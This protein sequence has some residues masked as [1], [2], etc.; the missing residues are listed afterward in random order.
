MNDRFKTLVRHFFSR[1][2][3]KDS[4]SPGAEAHASVVQIVAMLAL[5]G[6]FLSLAMIS[7]HALVRSEFTRRWLRAGD[8]YVFVSYA[9]VVMGFVMT[10][11]WDSLFPDRRDYIILTP[12][13]I[14]LRAFFAAKV[15][16]LC[17]FLLLF[18]IAINFFSCIIVPYAYLLRINRLDV[19]LPA[20]LAH[21]A[22]ALGGSVF[23][24]MFFAALQGVL[25]NLMTPEAFRRVSPWI[26]M[27]SMTILV[28]VL[29]ITPGISAN[30]QPLIESNSR[31][32]DYI[33]LFWF[34][35]VYELLNPEGTV[36]PDSFPWAV[37]AVEAT[38]LTGAMFV[39]T[40]LV[41]YRR[42]SKKILEG[43]ESNVFR[44]RWHQRASSRLLNRTLLRHPL[45]R[46]SYY[47]IGRIFGRSP[48]HRLFVAMYG[49]IGLAM[50]ISSLFVLQRDDGFVLSISRNGLL[51]APLILSFFVVS[52]LRATFNIPYELGANW[53]FQVT[54]GSGGEE[55]RM[56]TRKWVFLRGIVPAFAV[57]A[58]LQFVFAGATD[59]LFHLAFGLA[60]AALLT[61]L[62]F[63]HFNKVPFTCS[64]V[65]A[66]SHLAFMA[67]AY[68]YGFTIY[69][70]TAARL[71][72]W[73]W[74]SSERT[75]A[76]FVLTAVVLVAVSWY[77]R[78]RPRGIF[79]IIYQDDPEPVIRQLNLTR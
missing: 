52:G 18:V 12:L 43:I 60:M 66:K 21:A 1:F 79:D 53:M 56:A 25:I 69:T 77:G 70:F 14:S 68:L 54:S 3:D 7:D 62:F 27:L 32:L 72:N 38:I 28:T 41:S 29:V 16:A 20:F 50:T 51:E 49:G 44:E 24:A 30:L 55:H 76:F 37:R 31:V 22:A 6:A 46:G 36:I 48:R 4:I 75:I 8:H 11:K 26:Q 59:A 5:P 63:W 40:Y 74:A 78:H 73:V 35:G 67:A 9:M 2:F 61:E 19:I 13:P 23:M 65:P 58:P 17:T 64:Y 10:F 42:Y 39:L 45:Q 15:T 47:F 33:P 57:L 34:L 71:A